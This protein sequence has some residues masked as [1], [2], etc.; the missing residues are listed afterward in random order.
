MPPPAP[1]PV[2]VDEHEPRVTLS[3]AG[4][5]VDGERVDALPLGKKVEMV[6]AYFD[7]MKARREAWKVAHPGTPHP[8]RARLVLSAE[9]TGAS[10]RSV[11]KTTAYAG[12]PLVTL[13]HAGQE[14]TFVAQ[15]PGPPCEEGECEEVGKGY[16]VFVEAAD[17]YRIKLPTEERAITR[18][19]R[20]DLASALGEL[21]KAR[22]IATLVAFVDA[23][24]HA[25]AFAPQ[26]LSAGRFATG[27][28]EPRATFS[29]REIDAVPDTAEPTTV[30]AWRDRRRRAMRQRPTNV[31]G[32]Y[33]PEVI[34]GV[35][36]ASFAPLR[37]CYETARQK[38]PKLEG[39]TVTRFT[40]G[41]DGKVENV[42]TT[43]DAF[44]P[45]TLACIA[46]RFREMTFPPPE[47][48]VVTVAYPVV[49]SPGE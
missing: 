26:L 41:R 40:I 20:N 19:G 36:R 39:R 16:I 3:S 21:S 5:T 35:V 32:R 4:I 17:G 18:A 43:G 10:L 48:G 15:I 49:F 7:A 12:Y 11:F 33:A 45:E 9:V 1:A 34:Q 47:H 14:A 44:P 28:P 38:D 8:G 22:D 31:S 13:E 27:L 42:E 6:E 46:L 23:N 24:T 37:F 29:V 2:P 30:I 25:D